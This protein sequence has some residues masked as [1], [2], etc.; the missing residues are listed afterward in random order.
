MRDRLY[1]ASKHPKKLKL[2]AHELLLR[3][4]FLKSFASAFQMRIA[5]AAM[6]AFADLAQRGELRT[7]ISPRTILRTFVSVTVGYAITRH[8]LGLEKD[9]DDDEEID[10]I[11]AV[12]ADGLR[13]R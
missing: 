5:P 8:V 7:D 4:D 13:P 2:I 3:P 12:L 6:A 11:V 9:L 1:L 10:R